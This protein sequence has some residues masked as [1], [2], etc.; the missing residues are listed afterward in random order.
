MAVIN[1]AIERGVCA[2][3]RMMRRLNAAAPRETGLVFCPDDAIAIAADIAGADGT[4]CAGYC[5]EQA[6]HWHPRQSLTSF[7]SFWP[8]GVAGHLAFCQW[9]L[10]FF[11]YWGHEATVM[12]RE[13]RG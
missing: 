5:A 10:R 6:T 2:R 9:R 1:Y 7:E 8:G 12:V 13:P 4:N 3:P 11:F